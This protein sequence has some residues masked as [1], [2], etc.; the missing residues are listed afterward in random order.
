M[1]DVNDGAYSSDQFGRVMEQIAKGVAGFF[2]QS[3]R[4]QA[5]ENTGSQAVQENSLRW[6]APF[7]VKAEDVTV[8]L[9][10]G[11]SGRPGVVREKFRQLEELIE[12]DQVGLVLLARH[13]RLGRSEADAIRV[14]NLMAARGVLMMVDG[15]IYDPADEGDAFILKIYAQFAEYENRARVRWML[16]SRFAKAQRLAN[17][18]KLP[19]GLVW[20]S[21]EDPE[22]VTRLESAGLMHWLDQLDR[23]RAVSYRHGQ[24]FYVL[25]Y[26]DAEV[27]RS[28]EL[29]LQ[30][31]FETRSLS[32]VIQR[33]RHHPEWPRPGRVPVLTPNFRFNPL[34]APVWQLV[35][36]GRLHQWFH[37]PALYGTYCFQAPGLVPL[38][39]RQPSRIP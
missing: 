9:A 3:S 7:G 30:W 4:F 13:D 37:S 2:R 23:H 39:A 16:M 31:L 27:A 18:T 32:G 11:E 5:R 15:R 21:P 24:A 28:V 22:Y 34:V 20:A 1:G 33:I 38:H 8:V 14:F 25:P 10:Y 26:P 17:R 19:S 12:R 36:R 6:L 29:R 35:K